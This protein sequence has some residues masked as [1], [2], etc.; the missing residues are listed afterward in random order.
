MMQI[1]IEQLH[2]RVIVPVF[3]VLALEVGRGG[4]GEDDAGDDEVGGFAW[5]VVG[6]EADR[7]HERDL[8]RL[9]RPRL[10]HLHLHL[11]AHILLRQDVRE[12]DTLA[13]AERNGAV[14]RDGRFVE[15]EDDIVLLEKL[16][17]GHRWLHAHHP[18]PLLL[19]LHPIARSH[20][21]VLHLLPLEAEGGESG[22][23]F[24]LLIIS[25]EVVDDGRGND[26]PNVFA[27]IRLERLERHPHA[28][29][30]ARKDW[31]AA[32]AG[33]DRRVDLRREELGRAVRVR[34]H[35]DAA[36]HAARH[37][38]AVPSDWV[39]N[40]DD[41]ILQPRERP[42]PHL[43]ARIA[44]ELRVRDGKESQIALVRDAHDL[45]EELLVVIAQL[46]LDLRRVLDAMRVGQHQPPR[47]RP[48]RL[49][50]DDE[51]GR[52]RRVLPNL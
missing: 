22:E 17:R 32:V 27:L 26:V 40:H 21:R 35:L 12:G 6:D 11:F 23:G 14:V 45:G 18:H 44:P 48:R 10:Q 38:E 13:G 43:S 46:H 5:D 1:P 28:L 50:V 15:R 24:V 9:D 7:A 36:H 8:E 34:R 31:A 41:A 4:D 33:I 49:G 25:D 39:P 42:E 2:R 51:A 47:A 52:S 29:A 19:R 30:V 16:A 20:H 37:G 3:S